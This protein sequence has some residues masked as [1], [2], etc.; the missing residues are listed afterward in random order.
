MSFFGEGIK[1]Q[2]FSR[3]QHLQVIYFFITFLLLFSLMKY[4]IKNPVYQPEDLQLEDRK[5]T[6]AQR[7]ENYNEI[8]DPSVRYLYLI[9]IKNHGE[10]SF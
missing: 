7:T 10:C 5:P 1:K 4:G 3:T 2:L 9:K 6:L 8:I